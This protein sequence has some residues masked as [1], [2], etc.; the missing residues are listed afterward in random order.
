MADPATGAQVASSI[1]LIPVVGPIVGGLL[2]AF[3]YDL[4]IGRA[5]V[6]AHRLNEL[7]RP[8]GMDSSYKE[9]A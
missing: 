4:T 1:W 6:K 3:A 8:E 2:G 9:A 5:L 7:K